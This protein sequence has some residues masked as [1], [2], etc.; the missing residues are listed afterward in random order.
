[1][2]VREPGA[3]GGLSTAERLGGMGAGMEKEEDGG[4]KFF[5]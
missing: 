2:R 1:M 3:G 5:T 4:I